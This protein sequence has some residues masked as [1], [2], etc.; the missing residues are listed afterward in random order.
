MPIAFPPSR[1]RLIAML[2][3]DRLA[4]QVVSAFGLKIWNAA[5]SFGLSLLIARTF[6]AA[7]SGYFGIAVTT[8]AI[9]ANF[10]ILGLDHIT[11]R[12][13]SGDMREGKQGQARGTVIAVLKVVLIVAPLV[14]GLGWLT[15]DWL[16]GTVM[17][18][19]EAEKLLGIMLLAVVPL[20]LQRIAS[21]ALRASGRP[22]ASQVIDGA[23]GTTVAFIAFGL[24]VLLHGTGRL[25]LVG[26]YYVTGTV[27]GSAIG[28]LVYARTVRAWPHANNID[29][30]P[31]VLAG[32]PILF[33]TLSNVFTEW[34]TTVALARYWPA[35][36]VGQYRVAWQFVALAGLVQVAMDTMIGPRIA[37]AARVGAKHEIV[38]VARKSILL[39]LILASPLFMAL[40]IFP[41]RL[42]SIFGEQFMGGAT[43]LQVLALGQLFRL[44]CGPLGSIIVMTGS[45][46]WALIYAIA[47][48]IL[49]ILLV[50]LLVPTHGAVGAAAATTGT[51]VARYIIGGMIVR[52]ALGINLFR[53]GG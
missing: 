39:A 6:G 24:A 25:D 7:G 43:A 5:A 14:A 21:S 22:I 26:I 8:V 16:A 19:P 42:L 48:V 11:I 32:L 41:E 31:L 15:R 52:Y 10:V 44:V 9:L 20:A 3:T 17:A 27:V 45:Q 34:Y 33:L 51:V 28:W 37:A 40:L 35:A 2:G 50:A 13:V 1:K 47:G 4:G 12:A 36:E 46:L 53:K 18:Q 38:A 30:R 23:L 49:C 29:W